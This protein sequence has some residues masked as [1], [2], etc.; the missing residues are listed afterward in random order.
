MANASHLVERLEKVSPH[1][2]ALSQDTPAGEGQTVEPSPTLPGL[3]DP[4]ALDPST[5]FQFVEQG[6]ERGRLK[7]QPA[8]RPAFD[9]LS[10]FV[11]VTLR[12]FQDSQ[13]QELG[14]ALLEGARGHVS[15]CHIGGQHTYL[16]GPGQEGLGR[17]KQQN[18]RAYYRYVTFLTCERWQFP[19][20]NAFSVCF[21]PWHTGCD[22]AGR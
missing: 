9:K 3:F 7:L 11:S 14:A 5:F 17:P 12:T 22:V 19:N 4:A 8:V 1:P 13:N 20:K 10:N 2:A 21:A 15:W 6:I 16:T 18:A